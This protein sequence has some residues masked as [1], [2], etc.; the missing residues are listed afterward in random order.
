MYPMCHVGLTEQLIGTVEYRLD[1][2]RPAISCRFA[3]PLQE[4]CQLR[5]S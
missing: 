1:P 5:K 3:A 4:E 2:I